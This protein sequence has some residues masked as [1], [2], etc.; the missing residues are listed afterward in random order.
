MYYI[1]LG[2]PPFSRCAF[3][4]AFVVYC[5]ASLTRC[6]N[7]IN[8]L[9]GYDTTPSFQYLVCTFFVSVKDRELVRERAQ[10][11]QTQ[12]CYVVASYTILS[13]VLSWKNTR[14]SLPQ[15]ISAKKCSRFFPSWKGYVQMTAFMA[16]CWQRRGGKKQGGN[17]QWNFIY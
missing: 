1:L 11:I 17:W 4:S 15:S 3:Y 16:Q 7:I 14:L 5:G 13:W 9:N 10:S 8:G 12:L 2:F 6:T